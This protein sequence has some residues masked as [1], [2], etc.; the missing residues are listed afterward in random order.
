MTK[1]AE[2]KVKPIK[3][4][5]KE[6]KSEVEAEVKPLKLVVDNGLASNYDLFVQNALYAHSQGM[7]DYKVAF[8]KS[9]ELV[10]SMIK[11]EE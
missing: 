3:E 5:R 1:V 7:L 6:V 8:L 9:I 10:R 2:P 11:V 4:P